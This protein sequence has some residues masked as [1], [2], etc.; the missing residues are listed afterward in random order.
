MAR[1]ERSHITRQRIVEAAAEVFARNGFAGTSLNDIGRASGMTKGALYFHFSAKE[2]MA[3]AVQQQGGQRLR[4]LAGQLASRELPLIQALIDMTHVLLR[5]LDE[6][7]T[8]R[9][10]FRLARERG[11][12]DGPAGVYNGWLRLA[13]DLLARAR[14]LGELHPGVREDS[15]TIIVVAIGVGLEGLACA[16]LPRARM[17]AALTAM[18]ESLLPALVSDEF[19]GKLRAADP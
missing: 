2:D 18:W 10:S 11:A 6:E 1:Q 14:T 13:V 8:L 12:D 15:Y 9:A 7:P 3:T 5:W 4:A 16:G 17:T 19:L